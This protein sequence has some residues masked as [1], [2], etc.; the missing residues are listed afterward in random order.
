MAGVCGHGI[1][2]A[3]AKAKQSVHPS[4]FG[5]FGMYKSHIIVMMMAIVIVAGDPEF[6]SAMRP[7]YLCT[8]Y[9]CVWILRGPE[10]VALV[11]RT[12]W[13]VCIGVRCHVDRT[14]PSNSERTHTKMKKKKKWENLAGKTMKNRLESQMRQLSDKQKHFVHEK[15]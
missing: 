12:V 2:N 1:A 14:R 15:I 11:I 3:R 10:K 7:T 4:F 5:L 6:R 9:P 8:G 13:S